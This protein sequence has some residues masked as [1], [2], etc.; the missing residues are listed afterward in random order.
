[1][2]F[3]I[4]ATGGIV[5]GGE[6]LDVDATPAKWSPR[7]VLYNKEKLA[8]GIIEKIVIKKRLFP[9]RDDPNAAYLVLYQDTFNALWNEDDLVE[10]T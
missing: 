2:I 10:S 3:D 1:M 4:L 7:D 6:G 8:N 9:R 5:V